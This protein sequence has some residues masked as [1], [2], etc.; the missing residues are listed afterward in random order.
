MKVAHCVCPSQVLCH[1]QR[2]RG[3]EFDTSA[4]L[5]E[6]PSIPEV[7]RQMTIR[8][9]HLLIPCMAHTAADYLSGH[10]ELRTQLPAPCWFKGV[11][12]RHEWP[13]SAEHAGCGERPGHLNRHL[14][15]CRAHVRFSAHQLLLFTGSY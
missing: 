9:R 4:D 3:I 8:N 7:P 13:S 10:A 1:H 15:G 14:K 6:K 12:A 2:G 5:P 11:W